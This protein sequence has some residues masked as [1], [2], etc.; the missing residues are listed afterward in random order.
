MKRKFQ[1]FFVLPEGVLFSEHTGLR[2]KFE[3]LRRDILSGALEFL[4]G[5]DD[6][7][8]GAVACAAF[9]GAGIGHRGRRRRFLTS[10]GSV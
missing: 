3:E 4:R 2:G 5:S 1:G 9:L 7:R 8:N 10:A 6:L